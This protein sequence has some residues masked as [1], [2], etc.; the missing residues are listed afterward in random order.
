M[1]GGLAAAAVLLVVTLLGT[2]YLTHEAWAERTAPV[3]LDARRVLVRLVMVEPMSEEAGRL[4]A[5]RETARQL[6]LSHR[7][8]QARSGAD[9]ALASD[10]NYLETTFGI[11]APATR[12]RPIS[13]TTSGPA[14]PSRGPNACWRPSA[15]AADAASAR[16][17]L[18]CH[19]LL[20]KP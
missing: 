14:R 7:L 11:L 17:F 16:S 5:A 20:V 18:T 13:R 15:R 8:A 6:A 3:V 2:T 9:P 1:A 10:L 19:G 4:V 12:F